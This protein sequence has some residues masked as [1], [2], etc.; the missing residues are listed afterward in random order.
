MIGIILAGGSGTRLW[1]FS[2]TMSP[3][4]FLN[5]GSTHKSL[6]Q[7]TF[8][9]LLS[10]VDTN[11]IYVIGSKYHRVELVKQI[12]QV[13][14]DFPVENILFEP[15]GRNT[16]PAILWGLSCIPE[17][18]WDNPVVIL[19]ADHLIQKEK[20]LFE[21][22]ADGQTL[23]KDG[24][25]VTFG[26]QADRPETGY[27]YIKSGDPLKKGYKIDRFE[28]KPN[29]KNAGK[30]IKSKKYTWNS[31]IFMSTPRVLLN[32]FQTLCPKLF[33][34][35]F[36]SD[37]R[38]QY[39]HDNGE[40]IKLIFQ[41][42]EPDSIDYA[43]LEKSDKVA[44]IP[45]DINWND[46]G[47]WESIYEVSQKDENQN[48][49]RG[50][51]ILQ[52]S[53][54]CLIFSDK[55]LITCV[56]LQN[57]IIIETSDALLACDLRRSQDVK[58]LVGTL[59]KEDRAEYKFHTKVMRPWGS[60]QDMYQGNGYKIRLMKVNPGKSISLHRHF[61]RSEHW[62]VVEGTAEVTQGTD[63]FFLVESESTFTK[64]ATLHSLKNPGS[65]PLEILEVQQGDYLDE[66]D[67]HRQKREE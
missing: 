66:N 23:A 15:M 5:L 57:I 38:I 41:K 54:R 49:T 12:Q 61:H 47:S 58:K 52:D 26:I 31:G 4:Q 14:E 40:S 65:V 35:F 42:V 8:Q 67:I 7:D 13:C 45:M 33:E 27:G 29:Q 2:R 17:N 44:V 60:H 62:V 6:L 22:F 34:C 46:L 1:P 30:F 18:L 63:N 11:K 53:E 43:L 20:Q 59:K 64:K 39:N 50:N 36:N 56:G 37:M 21:Y 51:V 32:E 55:K 25:I 28:E 24:W 9:R 16:A 19:P 10:L 3:K 48:V